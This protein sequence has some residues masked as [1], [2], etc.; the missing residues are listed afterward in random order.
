MKQ[1]MRYAFVNEK[2]S[3]LHTQTAS[4]SADNYSR[5]RRAISVS[6]PFKSP[7]VVLNE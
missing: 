7:L 1:L 4:R 5:M 6:K 2:V 3:A